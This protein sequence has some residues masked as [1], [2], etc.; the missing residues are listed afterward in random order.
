MGGIGRL[1]GRIPQV[2]PRRQAPRPAGVSG[3][4]QEVPQR[5]SLA[6][7]AGPPIHVVDQRPLRPPA[8]LRVPEGRRQYRY[9]V[10]LTHAPLELVVT[11]RKLQG[12]NLRAQTS[13]CWLNI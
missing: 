1:L 12:Q 11:H 3:A 5:V 2:A 6:A 10:R 8:A 13:W 9:A 7:L 4:A